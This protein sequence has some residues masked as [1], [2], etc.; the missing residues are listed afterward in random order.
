MKVLEMKDE[1][2]KKKA[3]EAAADITGVLSIE[4]DLDAQTL[5]VIGEMDS[6]ALLKKLKS[7]VGKIEVLSI[8]PAA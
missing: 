3:I 4:S 6:V 1:K 5:V 8:G 7:K 2:T